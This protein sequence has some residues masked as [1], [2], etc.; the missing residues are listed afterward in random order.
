M[1]RI[2]VHIVCIEMFV[3]L[4]SNIECYIFLPMLFIVFICNKVDGL[5]A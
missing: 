3:D 1:C 2:S 4:L 5:N